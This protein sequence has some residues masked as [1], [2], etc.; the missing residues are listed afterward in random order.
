MP[1]KGLLSLSR[2]DQVKHVAKGDDSDRYED[3]HLDVFE[4]DLRTLKSRASEDFSKTSSDQELQ[5]VFDKVKSVVSL[6]YDTDVYDEIH[7]SI[8]RVFSD[9]YYAPGTIGAY[10]SNC[11]RERAANSHNTGYK[12]QCSPFCLSA[13]RPPNT[14]DCDVKVYTMRGMEMVLMN[15]GTDSKSLY[16]YTFDKEVHFDDI[17]ISRFKELGASNIEIYHIT[18]AGTSVR[19]WRGSPRELTSDERITTSGDSV[20]LAWLIAVLVLL[21]LLL[22]FFLMYRYDALGKIKSKIRR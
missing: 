2:G 14:P 20:G 6:T 16:I 11:E 21:L 22:I 12:Y 10:F 18:N 7:K 13:V 4:Q 19:V 17:D 3:I 8:M 9:E 5:A 15:Q 1:R